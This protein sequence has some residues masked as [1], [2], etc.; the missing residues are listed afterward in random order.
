MKIGLYAILTAL[1]IAGSYFAGA[2]MDNP[3]LAYAAG[4]TLTLSLFLWNMSRYA[5][6]AAQRKYRE[7]MFQQHMRMTLR[8]QWH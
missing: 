2:T 1:L 6:K 5:K 7:R 4:A 8:N 3:L